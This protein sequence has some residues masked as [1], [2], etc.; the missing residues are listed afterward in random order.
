MRNLHALPQLADSLSY[1]YLEH[2]R[3]ERDTHSVVFIDA[4]GGCTAIPV[5]TLAVLMLGPGTSVTHAAVKTLAENGC[6]LLWTGED[7]MRLYAQGSGETRKAY[8]LLHQ[9]R[10]ATDPAQRLAV[11]RRM[12]AARFGQPCDPSWTLEQIR[13]MEGQRVRQAYAKA[14]QEYGVPWHG[15]RYD[16]TNWARSDPANRALSAAN[17]LL[18]G[19]CHTAIVSGGYSPALGFIHTGE[20]LSFVYDIA[21]LYK[22]EITIPL[23][24]RTV[25]ESAECT[26]LE[27]RV[28]QA[29]REAFRTTRLLERILPDIDRLLE[30][31][32][33]LDE[34]DYDSDPAAPAPWGDTECFVQEGVDAGDDPG[35]GARSAAR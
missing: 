11:I 15:R 32:R 30:M 24:F 20:Q 21:D 13:G 5:A 9:A 26:Q 3:L 8:R 34:V 33:V 12:Y 16:R 18:S 7:G 23:A 25:A 19:I 27:A 28:R 2:G 31:P 35:T 6:L 4:E 14:S 10:M 29:C 17:A 1:L 22:A